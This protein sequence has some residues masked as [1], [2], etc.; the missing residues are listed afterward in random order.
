MKNLRTEPRLYLAMGKGPH[1]EN[2]WVT[3][4]HQLSHITDVCH[5]KGSADFHTANWEVV[6]HWILNY[7]REKAKSAPEAASPRTYRQVSP[8]YLQKLLRAISCSDTEFV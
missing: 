7:L 6:R 3:P 8:A 2:N 4:G 1:H 5:G